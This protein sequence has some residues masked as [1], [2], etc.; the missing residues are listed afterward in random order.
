MENENEN[1]LHTDAARAEK[2]GE[3]NGQLIDA[4]RLMGSCMG[5]PR[6][7]ESGLPAQPDQLQCSVFSGNNQMN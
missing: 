3:Q 7:F 6:V 5:W 2:R 4:A 1:V